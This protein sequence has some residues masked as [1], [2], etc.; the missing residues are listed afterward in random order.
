MLSYSRSLV[1]AVALCPSVAL[2]QTTPEAFYAEMQAMLGEMGYTL[3]AASQERSGDSLILTDVGYSFESPGVSGRIVAARW[4]ISPATEPGFELS[5]VGSDAMTATMTFTDPALAQPLPIEAIYEMPN[6][7]LLIGGTPEERVYRYTADGMRMAMENF[8]PESAGDASGT[9]MLTTGPI[10]AEGRSVQAFFGKGYTSSGTVASVDLDYALSAP[11][12]AM[13]MTA[14]YSDLTFEG[15]GPFVNFSDPAALF[16]AKRPTDVAFRYASGTMSM[17]FNDGPEAFQADYSSGAGGFEGT[18][19]DGQ[20]DYR[21]DGADAVMKLSGSALPFPA[22]E[23]RIARS[24]MRFALPIVPGDTTGTLA[25]EMRLEE[26]MISEDIWALFDPGQAIP[27]DPATVVLKAEGAAQALVNFMDPEAMAA[28]G[29]QMPFRVDDMTIEQ[30][31][32]SFGG[33]SVDATGDLVMNNVGP[34]PMPSGA[35]DVTLSGLVGL[36]Q[37]F[38]EIGL[39]PAEQAAILPAM[40]GAYAVQGATPDT[41]TSRVEMKPNGSITANGVP[42]Q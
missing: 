29:P 15:E 18:F 36:S 12:G 21:V 11:D 41:F 39:I 13:T 26:M 40:L 34:I 17:S 16:A 37:K 1:L 6:N 28:A 42:L 3:E 14:R 24:V 10:A 33:A 23:A 7:R 25:M 20:M 27:R 35:V 4:E 5:L 38:V 31:Q 22:A 30:F 9:M 2:A 32:V 8:M 19:G